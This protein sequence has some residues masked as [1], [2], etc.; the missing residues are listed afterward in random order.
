MVEINGTTIKMTR[1]DTLRT[2]VT[3]YDAQEQEYVPQE[4]E[5]FTGKPYLVMFEQPQ[6]AVAPGQSVV[7]YRDGVTVAGG[8]ISKRIENRR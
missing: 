1:G 2:Q 4:G 3:M 7:F 6:R 8:I 5:V